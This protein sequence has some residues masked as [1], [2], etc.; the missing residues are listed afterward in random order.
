MRWETMIRT[1]GNPKIPPLEE[2]MH[3]ALSPAE[4]KRFI[5]HL[6]PLVEAGQ[7]KQRRAVAYLWATK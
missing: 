1:A 7:G 6:R 5:E 3:T 2:A 4:R